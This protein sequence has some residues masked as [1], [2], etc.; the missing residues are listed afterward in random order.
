MNIITEMYLN[1]VLC[2]AANSIEFS[3][4]VLTEFRLKHTF[5][6]YDDYDFSPNAP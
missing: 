5:L 1:R 2:T 4:F 6:F 3:N